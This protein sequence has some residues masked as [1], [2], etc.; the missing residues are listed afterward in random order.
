MKANIHYKVPPDC[1]ALALWIDFSLVDENGGHLVDLYRG[2]VELTGLYNRSEGIKTVWP[3]VENE[4]FRDYLRIDKDNSR[5]EIIN[6]I[7]VKL[8]NISGLQNAEE[9]NTNVTNDEIISDMY[10]VYNYGSGEQVY[11]E[12]HPSV[13]GLGWIIFLL[14]IIIVLIAVQ[15]YKWF[16]GNSDRFSGLFSIIILL[17]LISLSYYGLWRWESGEEYTPRSVFNKRGFSGEFREINRNN[18][19]VFCIKQIDTKNEFSACDLHFEIFDSEMND[20]SNGHY[21]IRSIYGK[22]INDK[23]FVSFGDGDLDG[24]LSIGDRFIIKSIHH[25]DDD[26][27]ASPGLVKEG[28][29][30]RIVDHGNIVMEAEVKG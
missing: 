4:A 12:P 22:P 2:N 7:S 16:K 26:G 5:Y 15:I 9:F 24:M 8:D 20:V 19:F 30:F 6:Y 27:T 29:I 13:P 25:V 1:D 3:M 10:A 21:N 17:S 28:D 18:D 23:Y 11:Y 14:I